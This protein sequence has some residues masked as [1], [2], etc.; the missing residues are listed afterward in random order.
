MTQS[1]RRGPGSTNGT[2]SGPR[3]AAIRGLNDEVRDEAQGAPGAVQQA[4]PEVMLDELYIPPRQPY[5][6]VGPED[7]SRL[8]IMYL[9]FGLLG[10]AVLVGVGALVFLAA[11]GAPTDSLLDFLKTVMQYAFSLATFAA[12]YYFGRQGRKG[13]VGKKKTVTKM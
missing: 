13:K 12:G 1:G 6:V 11:R 9:I 7:L 8:K 2:P 10:G 5:P 4:V 3:S